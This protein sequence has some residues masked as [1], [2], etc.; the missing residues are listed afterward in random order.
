MNGI[1]KSIGSSSAGAQ[2][3]TVGTM[4]IKGNMMKTHRDSTVAVARGILTAAVALTLWIG[5]PRAHGQLVNPGFEG[6]NNVVSVFDPG[7]VNPSFSA[8]YWAE[9][10]AFVTGP[11]TLPISINPYEGTN[12][13]EMLT[14]G[15]GSYGQAWQFIDV[16]VGSGRTANLS[17][18]FTADT[19][20]ALAFVALTFYS[21]PNYLSGGWGDE[22]PGT[23]ATAPYTTVTTPG[24]WYESSLNNVAVPDATTWVGV[25]LAFNNASLGDG[26]GYADLADFSIVPEPATWALL[27]GG[28]GAL[29]F[30]MR[31]R[32]GTAD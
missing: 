16:G 27:A 11:V 5:A 17:A 14:A 7:I 28:F 23:T 29:S 31:R 32:R 19:S 10:N 15:T 18:W 21:T 26:T 9:E 30:F 24:T 2:K 25:Q 6:P 22:I 13:L 1:S 3:S 12:M 20:N 4:R 8:G